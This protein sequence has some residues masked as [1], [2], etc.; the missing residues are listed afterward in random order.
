MACECQFL[1]GLSGI[2]GR[3]LCTVGLVFMPKRDLGLKLIFC[4]VTTY[5][6]QF[7]ASATVNR[8]DGDDGR[9]ERHRR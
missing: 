5:F 6:I 8:D 7:F 2:F 1:W 3:Q 4:L 9:A